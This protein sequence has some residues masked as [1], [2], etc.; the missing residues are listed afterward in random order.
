ME[1]LAAAVLSAVLA[2]L[3][4]RRAAREQY[5]REAT[6]KHLERQLSDLY[7]PLT[8]LLLEGDQV[9]DDLCQDFG[10][11]WREGRRYLTDEAEIKKWI[12]WAENYFIPRN[13]AVQTLLSQQS[14]LIEGAQL[15][16]SF[17]KFARH[18]ASW[19]LE[20][21]RWREKGVGDGLFSRHSW[22]V[23]FSEEV[24][25]TFQLLKQRHARLL[26]AEAPHKLSGLPPP[27]ARDLPTPLKPRKDPWRDGQ[28]KVLDPSDA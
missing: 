16:P 9:F 13:Q 23:E 3:F 18:H 7:G 21:K 28:A 2:Y 12:Y 14:H 5:R 20:M 4:T 6:L 1:A 27:A 19:T 8:F 15:P 11:E 22:P 17:Q 24:E 26:G 10:D 25:S